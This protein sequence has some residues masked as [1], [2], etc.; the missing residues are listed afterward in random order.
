[1]SVRTS[2]IEF[3]QDAVD[4]AAPDSTLV[5]VEIEDTPASMFETNR[6]VIVMFP[7]FEMA[8]DRTQT[9]KEFDG[10]IN[11]LCYA[12]VTGADKEERSAAYDQAD[13][14]AKAVA[15]L[16]FDDP[17]INGAVCDAR[18]VRGEGGWD[19]EDGQPYQII[20]LV[21]RYSEIGPVVFG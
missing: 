2:I 10:F 4:N 3:L 14:L 13:E 6:G 1:M 8:P 19:A 17:T 12:R 7:T 5:G 9:L 21:L 15:R 20:G 16:F 18:I 11:L